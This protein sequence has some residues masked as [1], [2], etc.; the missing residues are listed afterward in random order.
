MG[1]GN[2]LAEA[3]EALLVEDA[4]TVQL[5][6]QRFLLSD[7]GIEIGRADTAQCRLAV[8]EIDSGL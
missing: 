5:R 6:Y 8:V 7:I 1:A 2:I 3:D 4:Q